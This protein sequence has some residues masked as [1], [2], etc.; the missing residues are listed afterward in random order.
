MRILVNKMIIYILISIF[1]NIKSYNHINSNHSNHSNHTNN[2]PSQV[3]SSS[4]SSKETKSSLILKRYLQSNSTQLPYEQPK[5]RCS[6]FIDC[7]NCSMYSESLSSNTCQWVNNQCT[8]IKIS[9]LGANF[10]DQFST[11]LQSSSAM[12]QMQNYCGILSN[13]I[14]FSTVPNNINGR[15]LTKNMY[16]MIV[17]FNSDPNKIIN[18]TI[19]KNRSSFDSD[20]LDIVY[21]NGLKNS[22]NINSLNW[23]KTYTQVSKVI[24]HYFA[25]QSSLYPQYKIYIEDAYFASDNYTAL[26]IALVVVIGLCFGCSFF[27]WRCSKI[28]MEKN[29]KKAEE[30]IRRQ[31]ERENR[32]LA[33]SNEI[34]NLDMIEREKKKREKLKKALKELFEGE[35]R[36]GKYNEVKNEYHTDC[37]IC[38]ENFESSSIV[39]SL[40]CKHIFHFDCIKDWIKKQKGDL[41]CPNCNIKIIPDKYFIDE[42][43]NNL[44][45]PIRERETVQAINDDTQRGNL[46]MLNNN[47]PNN[48]LS[49]INHINQ[50]SNNNS[51]INMINRGSVIENINIENINLRNT[52]NNNINN[53]A[54]LIKNNLNVA[55]TNTNNNYININDKQSRDNQT[56]S[57][58]MNDNSHGN[59]HNSHK[60]TNNLNQTKKTNDIQIRNPVLNPQ[61]YR[62]N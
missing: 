17:I 39:V 43:E 14:N 46:L 6:E 52:S 27:F 12:I 16:C 21:I 58:E 13:K 7:F 29:R 61:V 33:E 54:L 42:K 47:I 23:S 40:L 62:I 45:S 50:Y 38:I 31:V 32:I 51:N 1:S 53:N 11:C 28:I 30:M 34:R 3:S 49:N 19:S 20:A 8:Q 18:I 15:Y 2:I 44:L 26:I 25:S 35:L 9:S 22:E 57:L 10:Y 24:Y 41:K 4:S 48:N 56:N 37:T 60:E 5:D 55:N 59:K 36:P